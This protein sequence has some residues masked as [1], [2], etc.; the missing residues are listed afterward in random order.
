MIWMC[1]LR[2]TILD[3]NYMA[4]T[5]SKILM[6]MKKLFIFLSFGLGSSFLLTPLSVKAH[7]W[8]D[9]GPLRVN[10]RGWQLNQER[11]SATGSTTYDTNLV[12]TKGNFEG[13]VSLDC[14]RDRIS[15]T[16][17]NGKWRRYRMAMRKNERDLRDDFCTAIRANPSLFN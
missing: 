5:V 15:T 10:L 12:N 6:P 4:S 3:R 11:L 16:K 7:D 9:Y 13:Y 8:H 1:K 14:D 2:N 17:A